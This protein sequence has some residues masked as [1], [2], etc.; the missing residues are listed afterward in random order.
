MTRTSRL[1]L[2]L[3]ALIVALCVVA[4]P[5][6]IEA[7]NVDNDKQW[8]FPGF[9]IVG[10]LVFASCGG[11]LALKRSENP[12]GWLFVAAGLL[13]VITT[14][15]D[16][17]GGVSLVKGD[18]GGFAYQMGWFSSW[19]WII[20][21]GLVAMAILRFPDGHLPSARW[22]IPARFM[23]FGFFIG[24]VAFAF[25]PGP[26][27]N[28][29][30]RITNRYALPDTAATEAFVVV[31]MVCFIGA[32]AAST[33]GVIQRFRSSRGVQRQQMKLFALAAAVFAVSMVTIGAFIETGSPLLLDLLEML[34]S[35]A[36]V[37]I[38]VAMA[39]AI[40]RYRLYDIDVII[41]RALVYG[42]L[43][44]L[45]VSVYLG[46]VVL[47]QRILAPITADSDVAIAGS[48]LAVAALFRPLRERVQAF[49]DRRFYRHKY[50][51]AD[52]LSDFSA[53]LRNEVELA[54]V[55]REL[56]RVAGETVQ[57]AHASLWLRESGV[58]AVQ[59][60]ATKSLS[61]TVS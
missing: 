19:G 28:L 61:A 24:A 29:P 16:V 58:V 7:S 33:V 46:A 9:S 40:L 10:A 30:S 57:P 43:S 59:R 8:A 13:F 23:V 14:I 39:V 47:F 5:G 38:P 4:I 50:D 26:L 51:A 44:G 53:G 37:A 42:V 56:L 32:L 54:S 15:C 49:I 11:L 60:S 52:T 27:N 6:V 41:N 31:G 12:V 21:L 1:A 25:A 48:T 18:D 3:F 55:T 36:V 45:L 22:R 35:L 2:M 17:Y 20:F 34:N